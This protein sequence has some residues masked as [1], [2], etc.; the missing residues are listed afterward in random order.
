MSQKAIA[1]LQASPEEQAVVE[2]NKTFGA[3]KQT[4]QQGE[5]SDLYKIVRLVMDRS[6]D[7]AIVFSFAKKWVQLLCVGDT[8]L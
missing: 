8:A 7:P 1:K 5:G 3:R 2:G 4:K 6:L